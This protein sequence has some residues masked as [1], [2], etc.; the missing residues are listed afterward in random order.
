MHSPLGVYIPK[1]SKLFCKIFS[2]GGPIGP[3]IMVAPMKVKSGTPNFTSI[4]A[5]CR[6]SFRGEKP[7]NRPLSNLS[8]PALCITRNAAGNEDDYDVRAIG[9]EDW[10]YR[11]R[12]VRLT[13]HSCLRLVV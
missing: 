1:S 13:T 2:F 6:P 8:I 12:L 4:G 5:T 7:Q 10:I 11:R 3:T 9:Y